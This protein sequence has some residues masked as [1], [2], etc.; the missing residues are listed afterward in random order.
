MLSYHV[1]LFLRHFSDVTGQR[2]GLSCSHPDSNIVQHFTDSKTVLPLNKVLLSLACF[3]NSDELMQ[4]Q[5]QSVW[6]IHQTFVRSTKQI[7]T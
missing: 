7:F 3:I 5:N 1:S 4:D 6:K 2:K